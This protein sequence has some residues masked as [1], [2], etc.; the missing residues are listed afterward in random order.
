MDE[1]RYVPLTLLEVLIKGEFERVES[2]RVVFEEP[3]PRSAF[4]N[5]AEFG[6]L[7]VMV[8]LGNGFSLKDVI[9]PHAP[10]LIQFLPVEYVQGLFSRVG[11]FITN[12]ERM[13]D[14]SFNS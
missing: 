6:Q 3:I 10:G 2:V 14:E 5:R 4:S 12:V 8:N 13:I 9:D 7:Y 11:L 1:T